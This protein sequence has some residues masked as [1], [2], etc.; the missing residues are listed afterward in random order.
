MNIESTL[1]SNDRG[2][3]RAN[4]AT[5]TD[6]ARENRASVEKRERLMMRKIRTSWMIHA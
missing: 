2:V 4:S 5:D 6:R 3:L 1:L